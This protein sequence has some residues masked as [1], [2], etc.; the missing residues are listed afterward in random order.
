MS[1]ALTSQQAGT[2][3]KVK[4]KGKVLVIERWR[5]G[6]REGWLFGLESS[7]ISRKLPELISLMLLIPHPIAIALS[8]EDRP[9]WGKRQ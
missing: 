4:G 8:G 6:M 1:G 2:W 5:Q 9:D 3:S 7:P